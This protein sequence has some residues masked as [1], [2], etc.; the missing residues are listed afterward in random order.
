MKLLLHITVLIVKFIIF[1]I[2]FIIG[3]KLTYYILDKTNKQLKD[4]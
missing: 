4:K 1:I 2:A 3:Y